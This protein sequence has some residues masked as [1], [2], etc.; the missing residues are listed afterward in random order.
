M[1]DAKPTNLIR[2][3]DEAKRAL[4]LLAA[5]KGRGK[6]E[7]ASEVILAAWEEE[8]A[9]LTEEQSTK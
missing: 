5:S 1:A 6:Y 4:D 8:L 2:I 3:S 7:V 9:R